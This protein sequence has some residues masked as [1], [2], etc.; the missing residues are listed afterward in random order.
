LIEAIEYI[1]KTS[2]PFFK[3]YGFNVLWLVF[4]SNILMFFSI[5][6]YI[7][8]ILNESMQ[9]FKKIIEKIDDRVQKAEVE[10][11]AQSQN[12]NRDILA[13]NRN[14]ENVNN[15]IDILA[16][17]VEENTVRILQIEIEN[18]NK[19]KKRSNNGK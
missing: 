19:N 11:K 13:L 9:D 16:K 7:K 5:T 17:K 18:N 3:Q 8:T 12:F 6:R 15:N 1:L 10:I 2:I 4:S 14:Y